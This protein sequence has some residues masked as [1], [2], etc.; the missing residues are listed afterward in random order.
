MLKIAI[1]DD[2]IHQRTSLINM[3]EKALQLKNIKCFIYQYDSG[4]ELL[5][6]KL[7]M[8][9]YFLDIRMD[10][11]SGIE[12]AKKIRE[13]NKEAVIIFI[14]ALKEYVFQAFDVRAFHYIL[15]PITEK[16][17]REV[18][19]SALL[20]FQ[21]TDKFILGKTISESFKIFV[22][23]IFYIESH[24]RKIKVHTTYDIIEY[25]YKLSDIE[26]ELKD[27]NFF[28]CHKSYIVNLKYIRSYDSTFITLKNGEKIYI[29]KY[30]I[31]DFSKTF[32]YY[33]KSEGL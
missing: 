10:K 14:T 30:K 8:N 6:S 9:L 11:L 4:E 31:S 26:S 19:Y 25:Y 5:H 20:Q 18:L 7:E 22:K 15:K 24:L 12:T 23:D 32:M 21:E 29:S 28:R 3:I 13:I 17:L 16:K 2:E 33:L 1:C 27:C